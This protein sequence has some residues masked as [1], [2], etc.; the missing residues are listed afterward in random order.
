MNNSDLEISIIIPSRNRIDTLPRVLLALENQ[1]Y[2]KSLFEVIVIDDRSSDGTREF[3]QAFAAQTKLEFQWLEGEAKNAGAAR[4]LGLRT[5]SG[6]RVLFLDADTIPGRD[7]IRQHLMWHRHYGP[8]T[9][10]LGKVS[11]SKYLPM[12]KQGRVNDTLTKHDSRHIA[13]L[14][15]YEYRTANTSM[16]R[17]ACLA[18]GGFDDTLPAAEDTEFA[19]RL[20]N[21]GMRFIYIRDLDVVHHHPMSDNG[22]FSKGELYGRAA[23]QWYHKSPE[24][25]RLIIDRYGVFAP[26]MKKRKKIKYAVRT[27]WVNRFTVPVIA[28]FGRT[29]RRAWFDLADALNKCVF[30]YYVRHSFRTNLKRI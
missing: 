28:F 6:K 27:F 23:A 1:D 9:C 26:E 5:A 20:S 22:Y 10:V 14:K 21:F 17:E 8:N 2:P 13:E 12:H 19:S 4:N 29:F 15:W 7:L 18:A 30:R 24:L 16:N 25:R 3:L 11:M